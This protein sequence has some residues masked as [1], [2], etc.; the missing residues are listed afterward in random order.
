MPRTLE[1]SPAQRRAARR[2]TPSFVDPFTTEPFSL[3]QELKP[4][5][6]WVSD[7]LWVPP[8]DASATL[9]ETMVRETRPFASKDARWKAVIEKHRSEFTQVREIDLYQASIRLPKGKFYVTVT[10]QKDFEKIAEPIPR[11]VQTRLDEFLSGPKMKQGAK[12]YY[13]KPLCVEMGDDLILTTQE[14]LTAAITKVQNEIFA[15]YR[16]LALRHR[17]LQAIVSALNLGLAG[18]RKLVQLATERRQRALDAYQAK[19][20]FT[21]RKLALSVAKNFNK[22]RT[23]GCSFED[24]LVLTSPLKRADVIEQYCIE[25]EISRGKR[26]QLLMVA[27]GSIPWFV[28]LSLTIQYVASAMLVVSTPAVVTCD[29]AFVAEMPGSNGVV[30]KIGHFDEVAGVTHV[31]I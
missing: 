19:L 14:D 1:R 15:E 27:A 3:E 28:A 4:F 6:A 9:A 21:R 17:P 10:E 22:C 2:V 20:E 30:L 23:S 26:D 5:G 18:P 24:T 31:E 29:P 25:Q 11:C 12:V 8:K 16:R 13:I 7:P